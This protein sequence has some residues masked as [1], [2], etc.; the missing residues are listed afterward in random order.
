[1]RALGLSAALLHLAGLGAFLW[2]LWRTDWMFGHFVGRPEPLIAAITADTGGIALS[3]VYFVLRFALRR[4]AQRASTRPRL[5][6]V[7]AA[8]SIILLA[9]LTG[10][11]AAALYVGSPSLGRAMQEHW[12]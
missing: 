2:W 7:R 11:S 4:D 6:R 9:A 12:R 3:A 10:L 8:I 5:A 1:M